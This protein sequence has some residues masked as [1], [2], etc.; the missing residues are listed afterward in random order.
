MASNNK[1]ISQFTAQAIETLLAG[2]ND[3][4][5]IVKK[6]EQL[7][8]LSKTITELQNSL[9]Q[10]LE[11]LQEGLTTISGYSDRVDNIEHTANTAVSAASAA[12]STADSAASEASNAKQ[13]IDATKLWVENKDYAT[14]SEAKIYSQD[15]VDEFEENVIGS[16]SASG[17]GNT[18]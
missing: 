5:T 2:N 8:D 18:L 14:K 7:E 3:I 4:T 16:S 1:F 15:I 6:L 13:E 9:E 12:Q 17:S 11:Q 10:S